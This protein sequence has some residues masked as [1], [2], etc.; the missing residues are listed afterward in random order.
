M[1]RLAATMVAI[2]LATGAAACGGQEPPAASAPTT[3]ADLLKS[4]KAAGIPDC[5]PSQEKAAVPRGLPDLSLEC[6]GS[7]SVVHLSGIQTDKPMIINLWAQWCAPC[8]AEA[9][10]LLAAWKQIGDKT[11]FLG[12][13]TKEEQEIAIAFAQEARWPWPHVV[14]PESTVAENMPIPRALPVTLFVDRSGKVAF[15]HTGEFTSPREITDLARKHLGVG[16]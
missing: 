7:G 16:S 12:V 8:R 2:L 10:H 1:K 14:D 11:T 3:N 15:T 13:N 9:P 5:P 4:R 6:L